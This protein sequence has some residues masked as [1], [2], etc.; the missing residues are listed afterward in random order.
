[1]VGYLFGSMFAIVIGLA[2]A[3]TVIAVVRSRQRRQR[4][5]ARRRGELTSSE[6]LAAFIER[7]DQ[8]RTPEELNHLDEERGSG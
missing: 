4:E 2:F 3:V 1:M 5:L 7:V 8:A 6:A